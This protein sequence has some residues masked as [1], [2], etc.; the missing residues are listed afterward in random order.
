MLFKH[1]TVSIE[2]LSYQL[3]RIH[4]SFKCII[5][6]CCFTPLCWN[7]LCWYFSTLV[8]FAKHLIC[9]N[10]IINF[11]SRKQSDPDCSFKE[12]LSTYIAKSN[13]NTGVMRFVL[14]RWIVLFETSDKLTTQYRNLQMNH[15]HYHNT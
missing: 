14:Y 1:I 9:F 7:T 12:N 15:Y 8:H 4:S 5:I 3:R 11:Q 2:Q 13:T 6:V 10:N